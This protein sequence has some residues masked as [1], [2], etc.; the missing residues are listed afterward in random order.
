MKKS[1]KYAGIAAATLLAVAPVAA[2]VVSSTTAQAATTQSV[3]TDQSKQDA[4]VKEFGAQFADKA[5]S[6]FTTASTGVTL[7]SQ[8]IAD[9]AKGN[10]DLITTTSTSTGEDMNNLIG[11]DATV[12]VSAKYGST[13]IS[14]AADLYKILADD[15]YP[16]VDF[17]ITLN[18]NNL[19]NQAVSKTFTM[20]AT[21]DTAQDALTSINAKF[22]TPVT[23]PLNSTTTSTQLQAT[24]G[25][26]LTDQNG[27]GI[28]AASSIEPSTSYYNSYSDA[29]DAANGIDSPAAAYTADTGET[30]D[31][32]G[33]YYQGITFTAGDG[34]NLGGFLKEY[35]A[36]PSKYT[37]YVN[38]KVASKGYDFATD[39]TATAAGTKVTFVRTVVVSPS[40]ANWTVTA[41]KGVVTTKSDNAY[42]TLKNDD[43]ETITNRALAKNTAWVT[44]QKRVD[45]DGNTQ[46]RVATGEWIN[47]DDVTFSDKATTDEG[48]Y[49]DV[50]ALNGK[51][52][53]DGPSSFIYMLY[54]DNGETVSNRALAGDSAWYTDKKAT[55]A[56]GVTVYHVATG[57]WVQAGSGVN[58]VAY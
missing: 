11:S 14:N 51:V 49:T 4:A 35:V 17:T 37:V 2:P 31:K 40:E 34:S 10:A 47:A 43:N 42:Y 25:T 23:V 1:I 6:K 57:E 41:N 56:A 21:R 18:Y 26:T 22:T 52:T 13:T 27:D 53:L 15:T 19:N 39:A 44:D 9:F 5:A 45:Q 24:T 7:G 30:F 55:N 36:N 32:A 28:V 12:E 54:N 38:G 48:E 29:M 50:Q 33:T 16:A 46:Y 58:Y 8:S 3:A 20:S